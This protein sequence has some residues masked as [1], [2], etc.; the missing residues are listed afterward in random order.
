MMILIFLWIFFREREKKNC[1]EDDSTKKIWGIIFDLID[2]S[3]RNKTVNGLHFS[4][5]FIMKTSWKQHRLAFKTYDSLRI[6][7]WYIK[8]KKEDAVGLIQ[9]KD[10]GWM[11]KYKHT[12]GVCMF[13]LPEF[14]EYKS[15]FWHSVNE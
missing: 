12:G 2:D 9:F 5:L 8:K 1:N 10:F 7:V 13:P 4:C 11:G 14:W 15:W 3:L 6:R